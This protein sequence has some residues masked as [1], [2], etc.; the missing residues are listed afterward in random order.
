[1]PVASVGLVYAVAAAIYG[2]Q[3]WAQRSPWIF[4]DETQHAQTAEAIA[5]TGLAPIAP[6]PGILYSALIAPAWFL[7][8]PVA[9]YDLAKFIGVLAMCSAAVPA[10][11]LARLLVRPRLALLAAIAAVAIPGMAYSSLLMQEALAYP[12]AT[13]VFY[14]LT[15]ALVS[16]KRAWLGAAVVLALLGP[17]IRTELVVLPIIVLLSGSLHVWFGDWA[18]RHQARWRLAH[19]VRS[20]RAW[21]SV[22]PSRQRG[23]P[24]WIIRCISCATSFW[25]SFPSRLEWEFCPS[26]S[27]PRPCWPGERS[28]TAPCAPLGS[29]SP[30][31]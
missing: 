19:W 27:A 7:H 18:R 17:L 16:G 2:W 6:I 8:D 14:V 5:G 30:Q 4:P 24:R 3:A 31:A 25:G 29:S 20:Q 26:S 1:M 12:Y 11:L 13:L 10:Y 9:S 23:V 22:P 28:V 15:S 21:R